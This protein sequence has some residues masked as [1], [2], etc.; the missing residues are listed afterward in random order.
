MDIYRFINSLDIAAHLKSI[1][2]QFTALESAC[3]IWQSNTATMKERHEAWKEL[4]DS[5]PDCTMEDA[6]KRPGWGSLH[7]MLRDYMALEEKLCT[8]LVETDADTAYIYDEYG[9]ILNG[10]KKAWY[11]GCICKDIFGA[12]LYAMERQENLPYRICKKWFGEETSITGYYDKNQN[13]LRIEQDLDLRKLSDREQESWW[14]T[15]PEMYF[16]FPLPFEKGDLV[17]NAQTKEP[18]VLMDTSLWQRLRAADPDPSGKPKHPGRDMY[19][20]GYSYD[21]QDQFLWDDYMTDYMDL[22]YCT[23]PLTGHRRILEAYS[24]FEK[25]EIDAWTLLKLFRMYEC[26][27]VAAKDYRQLKRFGAVK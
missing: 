8:I 26:E 14:N 10:E 4:I 7:Q 24:C 22:E 25:G 6:L 15:F 16:D 9:P 21:E 18:F 12:Q 19:A 2:Y 5:Y 20:F 17:Q 11:G 3:L 1:G 23:E 27:E 13:L